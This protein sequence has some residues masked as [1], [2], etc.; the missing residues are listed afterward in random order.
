M[1]RGEIVTEKNRIPEWR[2]KVARIL[3]TLTSARK[4]KVVC[5]TLFVLVAFCHRAISTTIRPTRAPDFTGSANAKSLRGLYERTRVKEKG[6]PADSTASPTAPLFFEPPQYPAGNIVQAVVSGDFNGDGTADLAI[7]DY[8]V[9]PTSED[10][11]RQFGSSVNVLVGNG[12]GSFQLLTRYATGTGS[13]NLVVGDFNDDGKLDLAVTNICSDSSCAASSVSILLGKGDGTFRPHTDYLTGPGPSGIAVGDLNGDGKHDLVISDVFNAITVLLGKGDGSFRANPDISMSCTDVDFCFAEA[14]VIGD[15]NG[16][17]KP[18]LVTVNYYGFDFSIFLGNGDGTFQPQQDFL[19][20]VGNSSTLAAADLNGDGKLD[21]VTNTISCNVADS[22]VIVFGNGDGTFSPAVNV[23][24]TGVN[25]GGSQVL[26]ADFNED[27]KP[28][29][30]SVNALGNAVSVF[31]GVGDGTFPIHEA[32]GAGDIPVSIAAGDFNGDGKNDLVAANFVDGTVSVLLGNGDNTFQS[33][34][35]S[36]TFVDPTAIAAADFN[37]DGKMDLLTANGV[38]PTMSLLLGNG[39]GTFQPHVDFDTSGPFIVSDFNLDG[40]PDFAVLDGPVSVFLGMGDG[41]FI[42]PVDYAVPSSAVSLATADLNGDGKPDV[43]ASFRGNPPDE[44][45]RIYLGNGNGTFGTPV[46]FLLQSPGSLIAGDFNNDGRQDVLVCGDSGLTVLLGRGDGGFQA[47]VIGP[48]GV[49]PTF[50]ADLNEDGK[51]D[52]LAPSANGVVV[53]LGN[54][55]G[56][57]QGPVETNLGG[58]ATPNSVGDFD[59]DGKIDVAVNQNGNVVILSGRG[60]GTLPLQGAYMVS[61]V[62]MATVADFNADG[63]PDVASTNASAFTVSVLLNIADIPMFTLA[64]NFAGTGGGTVTFNPGGFA[65]NSNCSHDY[66]KRAA[67]SLS[68]AANAGST[69]SGWSGG[70]CSG[71]GT[72]SLTL[73]SD[74]TVTATFDFMP[75][76]ALSV[77]DFAPNPIS[78]GQSSTATISAEGANGFGETVSLT[79]SVQPSPAHAPQCSVSPGSIT[80]G[81]SA[82]AAITT[83]APTAAQIVT[84]GGASALLNALWMPMAGLTFAGIVFCS[85]R[86]RKA[87]MLSAL[88]G[89]VLVA[90]VVFQAACGG[91]GNSGG[92]GGGTPPGTYTITIKGTSGSLNHTTTVTLKVQ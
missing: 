61:G 76:F 38:Y 10:T 82:T 9:D 21:L 4:R 74:Q 56:S 34:I 81:N 92:G 14:V 77:S 79:C 91:G 32:W 48:S 18:D 26:L 70:G 16:D 36:D 30:A 13:I 59:A 71:T 66:A 7:A 72:C 43:I 89:S 68:A 69:F 33:R 75:D 84:S 15:F 63:K 80:P 47:P 50:V 53:L 5:A 12:D 46:D 29:I 40:K 22:I 39:N 19:H 25:C 52:L 31:P 55:D 87:K 88:L 85:P 60:D 54:G 42:P 24:F 44:G 2:I 27:N 1:I 49:C 86:E 83:T 57:F 41:R 11:C 45:L 23:Y 17:L 28:D 37:R 62:G 35:D 64:A 58:P 3:L 67:V 73:T 90:G 6:I 51:Q 20:I 8:C 78:P 65:C